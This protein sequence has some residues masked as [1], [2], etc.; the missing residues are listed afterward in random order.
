MAN[1]PVHLPKRILGFDGIRA[2]AAMLI[3]LLH[4]TVMAPAST[5]ALK[6]WKSVVLVQWVWVDAFFVLS[7]F[8][9]CSILLRQQVKLDAL[10]FYVAR[11]VRLM[12]G[13]ALLI[14]VYCLIVLAMAESPSALPSL[15]TYTVNFAQPGLEHSKIVGHAWTLAVEEQFYLL[16]PL[17]VAFR[18]APWVALCLWMCAAPVLRLLML[19]SGT[20]TASQLY[21]N[22]FSRA[23][24]LIAGC[25]LAKAAL[26]VGNVTFARTC[27]AMMATGTAGLVACFYSAGSTWFMVGITPVLAPTLC[28]LLFSGVVGW[29][30]CAQS[31][32]V[33]R[34][35]ETPVLRW[36]G[37]RSYGVYLFH[38]PLCF[39]AQ[40]WVPHHM[41]D[42]WGESFAW[43]VI[44]TCLSVLIAGWSWSRI[45]SP[46]LARK[47]KIVAWVLSKARMPLDDKPAKAAARL[48][49][50]VGAP[51]AL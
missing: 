25:L 30:V 3:I 46:I 8:L 9:V 10:K 45:E 36:V 2:I 41:Y 18:R 11:A 27:V 50:N 44:L 19:E 24:S 13:Y 6:L 31:S 39:V 33:V 28:A 14:A 5:A 12:P 42:Q 21:Y 26:H 43:V 22:P 49:S 47:D 32:V 7:G 15:L 34:S 23:D 16:A 37:L 38:M 1:Q 17:L 29:V 4:G 40:T 20:W 35:L 51:V 48:T